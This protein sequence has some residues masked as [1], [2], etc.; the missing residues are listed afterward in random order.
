MDALPKMD[1]L[2]GMAEVYNPISRLSAEIQRSINPFETQMI[3]VTGHLN[4]YFKVASDLQEHFNVIHSSISSWYADQREALEGMSD[5]FYEIKVKYQKNF[6]PLQSLT[7]KIF[8]QLNLDLKIDSSLQERLDGIGSSLSHTTTYWTELAK[9]MEFVLD[10]N[11]TSQIKELLKRDDPEYTLDDLRE[12]QTSAIKWIAGEEEREE[13]A[14]QL[15]ERT[16][17]GKLSIK[18][19]LKIIFIQLFIMVILSSTVSEHYQKLKTYFYLQYVS[20]PALEYATSS[21]H[22]LHVAI[23]RSSG[24]RVYRRATKSSVSDHRFE[25]GEYI[26]LEWDRTATMRKVITSYDSNGQPDAWGWIENN[27]FDRIG[28]PVKSVYTGLYSE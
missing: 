24:A 9:S 2:A 16:P 25:P 15:D 10:E 7:A 26:V 6:A 22:K 18:A 13:F 23:V 3:K 21:P 19:R 5:Y 14:K 11:I 17:E 8:K 28:K 27:R 12:A 1:Q 20:R 4:S